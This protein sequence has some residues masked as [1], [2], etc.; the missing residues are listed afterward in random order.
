MKLSLLLFALGQV[1]KIASLTH[2]G[3]KRHIRKMKARIVIKTR[4]KKCGR[5]FVFNKG[6]FSST[7][8][9]LDQFDAALV[10]RDAAA[11]FRVL[12]DRKKDAAFNAAAQG[13]LEIQG[14]SFYAQWF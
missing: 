2:Q 13:D 7:T 8:K 10:F 11:G 4:D 9:D 5:I 14:M 3:F 12:T 6:K 1:L